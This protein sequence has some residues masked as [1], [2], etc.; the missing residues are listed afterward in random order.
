MKTVFLLGPGHCGSTLFDLL[1]GSHS[2]GFSLGELYRL[3][4]M[5]AQRGGEAPHL[6]GVCA[7]RCAFWN[8]QVSLQ[9][10]RLLYQADTFSRRVRSRLARA[11]WNPYWSLSQWSDRDLL[12]D[13]SKHPHWVSKQLAAGN[14]RGIEPVLIHVV[15]DG[16]AVVS[17]YDRK[18]PQRG[19]EAICANWRDRLQQILDFYDQFNRG[20]KF[21]VRYEAL[22]TDPEATLRSTCIQLGIGFEAEMLRY[23]THDHHHL[24][25]NGGTRSMIFRY[26]MEQ[27]DGVDAATANRMQEAKQHYVHDYYDTKDI[28]ITLDERWKR[29]LSATDLAT[30]ERVA[31][32][33]NHQLGYS[34]RAGQAQQAA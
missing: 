15:R 13:S 4:H 34:D 1:L 11:I 18:Y 30:F 17:S 33:L 27:S 8:E 2:R 25:G 28:G 14:W 10:L 32:P 9:R 16:R 29:E 5:L 22:A 24:M 26:R 21:E 3:G 20:I 7:G 6:C 31:G 19:L 12:I 23:W